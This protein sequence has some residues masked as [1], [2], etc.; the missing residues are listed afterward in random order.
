MVFDN[1]TV[2]ELAAAI[3]SSL[4]VVFENSPAGEKQNHPLGSDVPR[5]RSR[6]AKAKATALPL[7]DEPVCGPKKADAAPAGDCA[8]ELMA[9]SAKGRK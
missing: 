7:S 8:E 3:R 1:A 2:A 5:L 4:P 6:K 9:P